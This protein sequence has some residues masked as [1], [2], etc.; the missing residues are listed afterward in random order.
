VGEL[1]LRH[2]RASVLRAVTLGKRSALLK[3]HLRLHCTPP[4]LGGLS[5]AQPDLTQRKVMQ[6]T[7]TGKRK[8][9]V[10][11]AVAAEVTSLSAPYLFPLSEISHPTGPPSLVHK[12]T[13]LFA[14]RVSLPTMFQSLQHLTRRWAT[15]WCYSLRMCFMMVRCSTR[16]ILEVRII[17]F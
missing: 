11:T 16:I 1:V 3:H 2:L 7:K 14:P 5:L 10:G 6:V 13:S 9:E 4:S 15:A 8:T 17:Y 12:P